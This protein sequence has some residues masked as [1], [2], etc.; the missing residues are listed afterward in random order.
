MIVTSFNISCFICVSLS[1][2]DD[3]VNK[4]AKHYCGH[5]ENYDLLTNSYKRIK[6]RSENYFCDHIGRRQFRNFNAEYVI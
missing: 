5:L 3:L 1:I 6:Y 2:Y 4:F